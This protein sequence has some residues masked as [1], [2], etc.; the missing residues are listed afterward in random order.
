[1]R[2]LFF[3]VLALL[4]GAFLLVVLV[5]YLLFGW[6]NQEMNPG[7]NAL[8]DHSL[9]IA[10]RLVKAHESG[11]L[12]P[13]RQRLRH[14]RR[15]RAWLLD[16]D[17]RPLVN[18]PIP[19]PI[20][21]KIDG[22]PLVIRPY[23]RGHSQSFIFAHEIR[24]GDR[25]YRVILS[26]KYQPFR[27]SGWF[28]WLALPAIAAVFGLIAASTLL[29]YWMLKPLRSLRDT[30][31]AIS[32]ENLSARIPDVIAR[33]KDAFGELGRELNSMTSRLAL[34]LKSQQQ[35]LRDVSH[36]LRS[37]LA[38]IQVAAS[39]SARKHGDS[40]EL[41]RIEQEVERLDDLIERLLIMSRLQNL[42]HLERKSFDLSILV[43][44][45]IDNGNYEFQSNGCKAVLKT[46]DPFLLSANRPLMGNAL[47]NVIR[48]ALRFSSEGELVSISIARLSGSVRISIAD[49]GS[50]IPSEHLAHIFEPFY[51][52][53][54]SRNI[55]EGHHGVGLALTK[56]IIDLH[57]GSISAENGTNG[58][59]VIH[60]LLPAT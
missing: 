34:A 54:A 24:R 31:G 43:K 59:L 58:G 41:G 2:T 23:R 35:L 32:V 25:I 17:N 36:E 47:E 49:Q 27:R 7:D 3:R 52:V 4:L 44:E 14:A 21:A 8:H 16:G 46:D 18:P 53:E 56:A 60:M 48:N 29:S 42:T 51:R 45:I 9:E 20:L 13:L 1:M 22:Y 38:R 12:E 11:S 28:G 30:A 33:R 57:G 10:K 5:S 26:S 55:S 40:A 37:P 6:I 15:V 50:G 39:V 19:P